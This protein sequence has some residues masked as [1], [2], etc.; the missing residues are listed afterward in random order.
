[1]LK[2]IEFKRL[3]F[4]P[5]MLFAEEWAALSA[6]N[7]E[8]GYNSMTIA[9]GQIGALWERGNHANR[10]P[11]L[12]CYVRPGRYTRQFMDKEE[13]FTVSVLPQN[14]K[15]ALGY[16]GSH[17]GRDEDKIANAGLTPLF[18]DGTVCIAEAKLVFVCRKLYQSPLLEEGFIDREL[19][20]FN[21]PK[22]DFHEMY[23]GEIINCYL[24]EEQA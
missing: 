17:S 16:L 3:K 1:M 21:Y 14:Y 5:A 23:V 18:T 13:L 10:L 4:N 20:D 7:E 24:E 2:E 12:T 8:D 6:G 15:K 19:V 11:V 9:W 22:K